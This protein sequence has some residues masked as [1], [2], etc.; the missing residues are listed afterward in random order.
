MAKKQYEVLKWAS[1]FLEEHRREPRVG[2]ILLQHHLGLSRTEFFMNMRE[3]IP[4]DVYE[5]FRMDL[6]KH[7]T[8]GIPLQHLTGYEEF[9]GRRFTV[10]EH[11]LIPRPETEELVQLVLNEANHLQEK[12]LRIADVGTGSGIIAITLA[13]EL[14]GTEVY[15]TD[16]SDNAL[17]VAKGNAEKLGA[18]VQFFQGDFLEPIICE[19]LTVDI[20]VSNPPYIA[21]SEREDLSDTVKNFDPDIALFADEQGLAAYRKIIHQAGTVLSPGGLIAFEIGYTQGDAVKKLILEKFPTSKVDIH[22]DI[23][24]KDRIITAKL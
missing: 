17:A 1:L 16:I 19:N 2:E 14:H 23:N 13:L 21:E 18:D 20:L 24:K 22:Q 6:E 7:A 4:N 3:T 8:T 15:A 12:S 9:F 11:V 5:A 10:N